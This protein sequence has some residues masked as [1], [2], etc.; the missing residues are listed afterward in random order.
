MFTKIFCYRLK[1]KQT[2]DEEQ[3]FKS[4]IVLLGYAFL[5]VSMILEPIP[6]PVPPLIDLNTAIPCNELQSSAKRVSWSI[7]FDASVLPTP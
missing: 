6:D 2:S 1:W 7:T 5:I 3:M 4:I